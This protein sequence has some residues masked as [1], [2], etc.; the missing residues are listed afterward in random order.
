M[1]STTTTSKKSR[2]KKVLVGFCVFFLLFVCYAYYTSVYR[3]SKNFY[4]VDPGKF[5]RSAQLSPDELKEVIAQYGIKTIIS[6]RGA[7]TGFSWMKEEV[8]IAQKNNINFVDLGF[9]IHY[10]PTNNHMKRFAETLKTAERPILV[11]CRTGSDRTGE[12]SAIYAVE[13]MG[14][15]KEQAIDEQL[16]FKYWH[17]RSF[18]PAKAELVRQW[19]GIDWAISTYDLCSLFPQWA[20]AVDCPKAR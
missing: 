18:H 15:S 7:P 5:Y 11:H 20:E 1:E 16:S 19:Q 12:A 6:L 4:E 9:T 3:I 10:F 13:F 17:V 8:E 14:K 2:W